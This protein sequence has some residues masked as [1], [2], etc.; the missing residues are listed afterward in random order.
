MDKAELM[1]RLQNAILYAIA[2]E[3]AQAEYDR[4]PERQAYENKQEVA[5]GIRL[6]GREFSALCH[7]EYEAD[8]EAR[9]RIALR[10]GVDPKGLL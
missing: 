2:L 3:A 6:V 7:V 5:R 1:Q 4:C 8:L 10:H 9:L